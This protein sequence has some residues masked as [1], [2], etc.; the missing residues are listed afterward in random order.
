MITIKRTSCVGALSG[1]VLL[2]SLQ[3][4]QAAEMVVGMLNKISGR[5]ITVTTVTGSSHD[6]RVNAAALVTDLTS[7]SKIDV[8]QLRPGSKVRV[9]SKGSTFMAVEVLE[10]PK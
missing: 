6:F 2:L 10:V 3:V 7:R 4:V 5:T 1:L 9:S 8:S